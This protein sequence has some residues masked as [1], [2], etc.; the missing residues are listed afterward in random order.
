M[1]IKLGNTTAYDIQEIAE[2]FNINARTLRRYI[3]LGR[4]KG[5]KI[6]TKYFVTDDGI[7][8]FLETNQGTIKPKKNKEE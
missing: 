5:N 7:K 3:R 1:S 4:L 2:M 6:G 8:D